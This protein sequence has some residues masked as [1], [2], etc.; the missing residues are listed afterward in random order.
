M[1][2]SVRKA[3]AIASLPQRDFDSAMGSGWFDAKQVADANAL[4]SAL[5]AK[6]SLGRGVLDGDVPARKSDHRQ[7]EAPMELISKAERAH[8]MREAI[9]KAVDAT[10]AANPGM[11][12][13][14]AVE[15]VSYSEPMREWIELERRE[16]VLEGVVKLGGG[17]LPQDKPGTMRTQ[18]NPPGDPN[19]VEVLDMI[20]RELQDADPGM[21]AAQAKIKASGDPR[22]TKAYR[23]DRERRMINATKIY[24]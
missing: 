8:R 6:R 1:K 15:R 20:A 5:L 14:Q 11:S 16:K 7:K 17:N 12:R 18:F 2:P 4:R 22:F 21:S 23:E 24:G 13:S 3:I 19:S 10:L 9:R